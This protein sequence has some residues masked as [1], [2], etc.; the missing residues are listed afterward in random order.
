MLPLARA[1]NTPSP[2]HPLGVDQVGQPLRPSKTTVI[3]LPFDTLGAPHGMVG[4]GQQRKVESHHL[5][6]GAVVLGCVI[7]HAEDGG[8]CCLE[9]RGSVTEPLPFERSAGGVRL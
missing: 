1:T 5:R 6:P 9:F 2:H 4:V 8:T 3:R 7:G